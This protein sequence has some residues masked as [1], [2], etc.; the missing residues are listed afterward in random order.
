MNSIYIA[1]TPYHL[2]ISCG[3]A[4]KY[5]HAFKKHLIFASDFDNAEKYFNAISTWTNCPFTTITLLPGTYRK[6]KNILSHV[7]LQREK[8]NKLNEYL[9]EIKLTKCTA[10]IF[11]DANIEGQITAFKN[12]KQG[13]YNVYME[14]GFAAYSNGK[15]PHL[16]KVNHSLAKLIYGSWYQN[17]EILGKSEYIDE[18]KVFF[19]KI[20]RPELISSKITQLPRNIL[21]R[22]DFKLIQKILESLNLDNK[23]RQYDAIIILPHSNYALDLNYSKVRKTYLDIITEL[24][25]LDYSIGI[26]YH[27][28]ELK[29]NYLNID[30]TSELE[31]IPRNIPIE[32]QFYMDNKKL[33]KCIIGDS[34]TG[35]LSA[36]II[37][38]ENVA[39]LSINR[40][41][42]PEGANMSNIFDKVNIF[43][44]GTIEDLKN[45]IIH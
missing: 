34:S 23:G 44:P 33:P 36:K 21:T 12:K 22:P 41:I 15:L 13:G 25:K 28:R 4:C 10:Y 38:E 39:I 35:L 18:I 16:G 19:P 3:Y 45:S 6:K 26:K 8:R 42:K 14:D 2:L 37:F 27:P 11:N 32:I 20:I 17:V 40:M 31:E 24:R 29:A 5:D 43:Q 1:N 30:F 9:D 7:L